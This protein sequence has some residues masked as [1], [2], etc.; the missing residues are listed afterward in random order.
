MTVYGIDLYHFNPMPDLSPYGFVFLKATQGSGFTDPLFAQ[1]WSIIHSAGKVCGAYHFMTMSDSV[2]S[3][4]QHFLNVA[5][6]KSGDVAILDFENDGSWS[7][8]TT[9]QIAAVAQGILN[10]IRAA[11]PRNRLIVYCNQSDHARFISSGLVSPEDG[12][13][14]ADYNPTPPT[15]PF[16]FW[17]YSDSPVDADQE[18]T[19]PT[20]SS[21]QM[22]AYVTP[23]PPPPPVGSSQQFQLVN[24]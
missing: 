14:A 19:Y 8:H 1:R 10:Y 20:L 12:I 6:L 17:Q 11:V 9:G 4:A 3:Q 7:T 21:L 15:F 22:W 2:S 5:N 24:G 16:L 13:W 23:L 18:S